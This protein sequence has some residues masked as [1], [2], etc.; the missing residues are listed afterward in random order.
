[1]RVGGTQRSGEISQG[2]WQEEKGAHKIQDW[3]SQRQKQQ[4]DYVDGGK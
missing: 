4:K 3:D 1:M 2:E